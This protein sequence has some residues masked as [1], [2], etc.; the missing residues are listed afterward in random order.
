L[1]EIHNA[2]D[3]AS[4]LAGF[5]SGYTFAETLRVEPLMPAAYLRNQ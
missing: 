3:G 4:L 5:V 2:K 1:W